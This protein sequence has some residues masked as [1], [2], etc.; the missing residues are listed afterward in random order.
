M[1]DAIPRGAAEP[2]YDCPLCPRLHDF[3]AEWRMKEPGWFNGPVPTFLPPSD[4]ATVKLLIVG[5]APGLRGANR[6][7]R[8]FTGDYAG[9]LLYR[10]LKTFGFA[11]GEFLA[12]PDD[13]LEL[14][15][16][17]ITNAVRCVPPANK[18]E[19]SEINTCRGFLSATVG[20][21]PNLRAVVTLGA[22]A[23]QSTIRALGGR[24]AA[25]PFKHGAATE[26]GGLS[27]FS[28]YHCSRY[29]TNTGV[30]TEEMFADVF[31]NVAKFLDQIP[32]PAD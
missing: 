29:N 12:R 24:V 5:L 19:S 31:A 17:A 22:I 21:F 10:T 32:Q 13:S 28:S 26:I 15:G 18:P 16:T 14:I 1:I 6:T 25:H 20:R 9:D 30:L 3:V 23:H 27:V 7:G 8:P 11:H 2:P 4:D